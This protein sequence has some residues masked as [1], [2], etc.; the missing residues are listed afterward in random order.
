MFSKDYYYCC[1][2]QST[3]VAEFY[4]CLFNVYYPLLIKWTAVLY[5]C[6]FLR[7][8]MLSPAQP[9]PDKS[10]KILII[11][12]LL[13]VTMLDKGKK[14]PPGQPD[15]REVWQGWFLGNVFFVRDAHGTK[16]PLI[17]CMLCPEVVWNCGSILWPWGELLM[18]AMPTS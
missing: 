5:R 8:G 6:L 17:H 16:W 10:K 13:P 11:S 7:E 18:R 15:M 14:T 12:F 3:M 2:F 9:T 1:Y 4:V